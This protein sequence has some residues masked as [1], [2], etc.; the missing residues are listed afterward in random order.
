MNKIKIYGKEYPIRITMWPC[1]DG[2]GREPY[3]PKII[4]II[5]LLISFIL[6]FCK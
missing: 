6:L 4:H 3:I 5:K 1:A 2:T